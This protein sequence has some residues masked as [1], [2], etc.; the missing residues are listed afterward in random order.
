LRQAGVP[1]YPVLRA[2]DL[3]EDPQLRARGFFI[4]LDHPRLGRATFEGATTHFSQTP[5][6]P[7]HAG[8]TI[9]QHTFETLRDLLGYT[10]QQ[11]THLAANGALT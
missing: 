9:G 2:T 5:A 8:P 7:L 4:P 10:E 3:Y 11:I 6:R 1:A